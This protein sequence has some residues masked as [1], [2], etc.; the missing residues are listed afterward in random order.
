MSTCFIFVVFFDCLH[1]LYLLFSLMSTCFIFVVPSLMS[2]CFI[3]VVFFDVYMF[4]I[5]CSLWLSTS[6]I[7]VVVEYQNKQKKELQQL[8]LKRKHEQYI[9]DGTT[10]IK[11]VDIKENCLPALYLLFSLIVYMFYIC[12]FLWCLPVL[13]FLFSLMSTCFIFVVPSLMST[14]FIFVVRHQREQQI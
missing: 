3:F 13:Y 2:T 11:Q 12:C 9:K 6:F 14:C 5:C 1:V 7:F 10:N 4:Y 8:I